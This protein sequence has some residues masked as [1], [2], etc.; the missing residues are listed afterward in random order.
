ML[1]RFQA[2]EAGKVTFRVSLASGGF[3]DPTLRKNP[4][5]T[6]TYTTHR[7]VTSRISH[8]LQ[9]LPIHMIPVQD[10]NIT[11]SLQH[12]SADRCQIQNISLAQLGDQIF[13]GHASCAYRI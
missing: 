9:Y 13:L 5:A 10:R 6:D 1:S 12:G 3:S 8:A 7:D 11:G 4:P 2:A